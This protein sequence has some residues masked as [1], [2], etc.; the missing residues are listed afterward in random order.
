VSGATD[1]EIQDEQRD[2]DGEHTI[3]ERLEPLAVHRVAGDPYTLVVVPDGHHTP[4]KA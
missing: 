2:R 3:A 4:T 1:T